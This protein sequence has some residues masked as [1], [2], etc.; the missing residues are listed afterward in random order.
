MHVGRSYRLLDFAW[1]TRRSALYMAVL[2]VVAVL[3]YS[4][5][6]FAGFAVPWPIVL[7]LG[8]TVS[9]VSGFKN[10]Q[11]LA[12]ASEALAAF[13]TVAATS[14][15]LA[16]VATAALPPETARAIVYRHLSWLT[17]LRFA[18]RAPRPW[19]STSLRPNAEYRRRYL[20][21]AEDQT[22]LAAELGALLGPEAETLGPGTPATA[23]LQR[24]AHA[25]AALLRDGAVPPPIYAELMKV[26]RDCHDTEARCER[27]KGTPYPRQYAIVTTMF[28]AIFCTLLPFGAT[29]MFAA[30]G[31]PGL[32]PALLVWLS[33][34]F[35]TLLGWMYFSLDLVGESTANP[36]EGNANDVPISQMCREIEIELRQRLGETDLPKPVE[37][38]RGIVT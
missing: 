31:A 36:F 13:S 1:W 17:A 35:S 24:Q 5:P 21:I 12:R 2:S 6:P 26:L 29:P 23:L 28:V 4:L 10:A 3:A 27:I 7:V 30:I 37:P 15:M 20:R 14:R 32:P 9:L 19:E 33:V 18:L 25:F 11:V 16:G 34:P 22:T 38:V 8:T